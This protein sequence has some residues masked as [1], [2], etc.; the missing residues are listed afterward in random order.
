MRELYHPSK[1]K[2]VEEMVSV[3]FLTT[4]PYASSTSNMNLFTVTIKVLKTHIHRCEDLRTLKDLYK[5]S[6]Y[7]EPVDSVT[8]HGNQLVDLVSHLR[9]E[10]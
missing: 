7:V 4:S 10:Y 1:G 3:F 5:N 6:E 8:G 9:L 2:Q